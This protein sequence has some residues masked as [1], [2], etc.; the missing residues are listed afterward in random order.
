MNN[1]RY[2]RISGK[3]DN[4]RLASRVLEEILQQA[5]VNGERH[6]EVDAF[7]QHGLGGRLWKA[8][9]DPV[10]LKI[11]GQGGQRVGAMGFANTFIEI[12]GPSS[13]DLGWLNA[14]AV[15]ICILMVQ[16]VQ[17]F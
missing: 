15:S 12:M 8:G 13:D 4:I 14:G 6:I 3:K 2:Y 5:V 1:Q 16:L 17:N 11:T 10:Y 7:G 9:D